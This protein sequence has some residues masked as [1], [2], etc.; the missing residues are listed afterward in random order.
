M[1]PA[2][3]PDRARYDGHAE[4]YDATFSHLSDEAGSAGLLR[5][6][7][8]PVA[9]PGDVCA[10]IGCGTGLHFAAV[11]GRGYQIIGFDLSGDQLRIA[12]TRNSQVTV[13]DAARLPLPDGRIAAAVMTFVHTDVED[14]AAAV[15]EAARIVRPGGRIIYL[16]VHP[17][18][19][20][21]FV[22]RQDET[23]RHALTFVPGYGDERM[24]VDPSGRFPI[25]GRVGARNLTLGTLLNAFLA[26]PRL[27]VSSMI[28]LY[29]RM[30]PW[31]AGSPDGR[32]VPWNIAVTARALA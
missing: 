32:V 25:R 28:E 13:A 1:Q 11:R 20:G 7:L 21:A 19:V 15:G 9:T 8:G 16:G 4:W 5:D 31:R 2:R 22:S 10:D 27:R 23:Q 17:A 6:L 14:F 29:T 12:A 26:Q 24:Q 3:R 18:Y 30:R